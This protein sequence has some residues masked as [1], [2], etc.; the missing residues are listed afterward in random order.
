MS[1]LQ[2][3]I[4]ATYTKEDSRDYEK[5]THQRWALAGRESGQLPRPLGRLPYGSHLSDSTL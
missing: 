1:G 2:T 5:T 3:D 4:K